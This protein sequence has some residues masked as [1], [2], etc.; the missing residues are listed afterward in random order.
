MREIH[1]KK[2]CVNIFYPD[3]YRKW[4][5]ANPLFNLILLFTMS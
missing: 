4:Q 1:I 2:I 5:K 3:S